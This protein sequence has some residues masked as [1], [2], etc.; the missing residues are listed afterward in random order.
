MPP[1]EDLMLMQYLPGSLSG[2]VLGFERF[3]TAQAGPSYMQAK[4]TM[5]HTS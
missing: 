2:C 5:E 4:N 1:D 3:D